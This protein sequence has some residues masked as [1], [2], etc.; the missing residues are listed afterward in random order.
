[1]T[2]QLELRGIL[3]AM[4]TPFVEDGSKINVAALRAQAV[5]LIDAGCGGLIPGGSTGEFTSLTT[6][7]RKLL[8]AAVIEAAAGRVPVIAQTGAMT[9]LE[10]I[11]L[12]QHAEA[13]GAAGI[14]VVPPYYEGLSFRE[15]KQYF[16]D[17]ASSVDIPV[18]LYHIP[19][20]TNVDLTP[21]ELGELA[22]VPGI[23]LVKDSSADASAM[24][25]AYQQFGDRLQI[26]NGW[27]SL[28]F[29]SLAAGLKAVVW[30][31]ACIFPELAVELYDTV[32]VKR[33]L[34]KGQ[35]VWARLYPLVS[36][37][38]DADYNARVKASCQAIGLDVGHPRKPLLPISDSDRATLAELISGLGIPLSPADGQKAPAP[39]TEVSR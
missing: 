5:R 4:V 38:E 30:G 8:H 2:R 36:F 29:V 31:A 25:H 13:A 14:M 3:P 32:A 17:V 33:D 15:I 11:D 28:T 27:D 26:C 9:T 22:S 19:A 12:S 24:L 18:M 1:M 37:L 23:E 21:E 35:Q 16:T 10:A 34:E 20:L 39:L 7:E 6:A